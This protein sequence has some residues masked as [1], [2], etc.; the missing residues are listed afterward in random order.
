MQH[1]VFRIVRMVLDRIAGHPPAQVFNG[2]LIAPGK[3]LLQL[4]G[5]SA[6][7]DAFFLLVFHDHEKAVQV[8][9]AQVRENRVVGDFVRKSALACAGLERP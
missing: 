2:V 7:R 4:A 6:D 5:Q 8:D 1:A 9:L 3:D